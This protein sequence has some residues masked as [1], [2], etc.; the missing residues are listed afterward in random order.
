M[1]KRFDS[2]ITVRKVDTLGSE[3]EEEEEEET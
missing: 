2:Y 1:N 3:T